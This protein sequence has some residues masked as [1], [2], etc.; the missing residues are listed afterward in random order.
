MTGELPP[1]A[2]AMLDRA[3][4]DLPEPDAAP[5]SSNGDAPPGSLIAGLREQHRRIAARTSHVFELPLWQG[6]LGIRLRY[7]DEKDHA[8]LIKVVTTSDNDPA[9]LNRANFDLVIAGTVE[10]VAR[11]DEADEWGPLVDGETIRLD[12]R[13]AELLKLGPCPTA[14]AVLTALF[15]TP[16][17]ANWAVGRLSGEYVQWLTGEAPEVAEQFAGESPTT[18][19]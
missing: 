15:D 17:K 10:I 4:A 16:A 14:R 5:A 12:A 8:R 11:V 3:R 2:Q 19:G 6:K 13:L 9:I 7:S 1:Q 18:G